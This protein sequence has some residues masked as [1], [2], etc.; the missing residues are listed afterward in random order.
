MTTTRDDLIGFIED[1]YVPQIP[2]GF[3]QS[4][5]EAVKE[6]IATSILLFAS[7]QADEQPDLIGWL[8]ENKLLKKGALDAPSGESLMVNGYE[9]R[10]GEVDKK[11]SRIDRQGDKVKDSAFQ[12][13]SLRNKA[14][15]SVKDRFYKLDG[16][17]RNIRINYDANGN[18]LPLH[19]SE[20]NRAIHFVLDTVR[21]VHDTLA[22][23]STQ[24][25][26]HAR[27]IDDSRP[28][29]TGTPRGNGGPSSGASNTSGT[30]DTGATGA[31]E[32][33]PTGD[34]V[35]DILGAA[36]HELELGVTERNGD[37]RPGYLDKESGKW[38]YAPYKLDAK[39]VDDRAWCASFAT[40]AWRQAGIK[41]NWSNKDSVLSLWQDAGKAG[42]QKTTNLAKA[43]PGDMIVLNGKQHVGIVESVN[44]NK[45]TTIEG[46]ASDRVRRH[47]YYIGDPYMVGVIKVPEPSNAAAV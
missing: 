4:T 36:R 33:V 28:S 31:V 27:D 40:Y 25:R 16:Q 41:V 14:F 7:G 38:V 43:A 19:P 30:S 15:Q 6:T 35:N 12:A 3:L 26:A 5:I 37:N 45:I 32:Y 34:T 18:C 39:A 29:F 20:D 9:Q 2:S 23:A 21:D 44:G 17:L 22:K 1:L 24:M 13:F 46:N 10:Q 11:K 8:S 47:T 42:L